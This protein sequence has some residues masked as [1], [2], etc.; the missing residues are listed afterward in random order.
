MYCNTLVHLHD[1]EEI[2]T[3]FKQTFEKLQP[4][5]VFIFQIVNYEKKDFV[6]PVMEKERFK[7]ERQYEQDG[8][9]VLFT[10]TLTTKDGAHT[11]TIPL[12]PATATQ[13]RRLLE[14]I[15]FDSINAYANF[16]LKEYSEDAPAL[17]M[18][19]KK[20]K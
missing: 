10:T 17:I 1:L 15:G 3:F 8:D 18:V 5:G 9:H 13:L 20:G 11:N 16:A 19:M 6:F 2:G 12:Y 7:F 4:E 14:K